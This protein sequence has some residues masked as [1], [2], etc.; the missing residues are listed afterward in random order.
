MVLFGDVA[1]VLVVGSANAASIFD[2]IDT[3]SCNSDD[4]RV[5][6]F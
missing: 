5:T 2:S 1:G 3:V 6:R 4:N